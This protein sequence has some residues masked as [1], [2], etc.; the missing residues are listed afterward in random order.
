MVWYIYILYANI[1]IY[2]YVML[3]V[4]WAFIINS[5]IH[6]IILFS[7]YVTVNCMYIYTDTH[8]LIYI[9][10]LMYTHILCATYVY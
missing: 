1:Y 2:E 10:M 7:C 5:S 3:Y 4:V 9:L 8:T 6:W